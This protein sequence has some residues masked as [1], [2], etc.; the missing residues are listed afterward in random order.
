MG[1]WE[2]NYQSPPWTK[3]GDFEKEAGNEAVLRVKY[4]TEIL[5]R[6]IV[7]CPSTHMGNITVNLLG[8]Q[9]MERLLPQT[10]V[11]IPP[12]KRLFGSFLS[13]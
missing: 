7:G 2:A 12:V 5:I 1:D 13:F 4:V 8:I 9:G 3:F 11:S 10:R 6:I